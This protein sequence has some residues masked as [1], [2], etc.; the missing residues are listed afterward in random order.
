LI[1]TAGENSGSS[2]NESAEGKKCL[3]HMEKRGGKLERTK[4]E[5]LK[6]LINKIRKIITKKG[7]YQPPARGG[8]GG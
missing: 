4:R 6:E 3:N 2:K 8:G 5:G 1:R 7:I